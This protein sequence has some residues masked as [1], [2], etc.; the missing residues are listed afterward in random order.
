MALSAS[1]LIAGNNDVNDPPRFARASRARKGY[2]RNVN[3]V[4]SCS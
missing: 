3:E 1:G 4:C 2:P